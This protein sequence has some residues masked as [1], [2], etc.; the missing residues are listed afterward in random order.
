MTEAVLSQG[1]G[2]GIVLGLGFAFALLMIGVT[3]ILS[4][5]VGEIQDSEHF[6]T[7]S[8]SVKTGLISAAVVS[9]WTWPGTLLT[10]SGMAYEYGAAGCFWYAVGFTIQVTFFAVLA[11]QVKRIAPGAHTLVEIV[12]VR[13]G[14]AAHLVFLFYALGTNII[15]SAMLLLGGSQAISSITGMHVVAAGFLLP[16]GVWLYTVSGGLKSTFLSDWT[17]TVIVYVVIL[18]TLFVAYTSSSHI[19]SIDKMYELLTEVAK[20]HPS[21]GHEGSYLT[22]ANRDALFSG[23][24]IAIGGFA[25]VF[26]DPSYGQKAI[27]AKPASAMR[28]YIAGGLSWLIVPWAMGTAASLSC[29]ALIDNPVSVTYPDVVSSKEVAEGMPLL[30]GMT[31]LMGKSGASAGVLILFMACTSATSAELIAFSSVMTYD[32]YRTYLRPAA[33]GKELMNITHLFVTVFAVA[34]G[35]LAVLFNYIGITISW[36]LTFIGIALGPA[37]FGISL[38]L[39]WPKMS[40][41]GM[42]LGCPL[43]SVTGV[44]CW[45]ASS[46]KFNNGVVNKTT[47]NTADANAVGNFVGLF[48]GLLYIVIFSYIWPDNYDFSTMDSKFTVGDDAT[49]EEAQEMEIHVDEKAELDRSL[50]ISLIVGVSIFIALMILWPLPMFGSNYI[51]SKAFFRGWV[52]VIMIWC[53]IAA[54]YITFYP[55]YESRDVLIYLFNVL[56]GKQKAKKHPAMVHDSEVIMERGS[57][58]DIDRVTVMKKE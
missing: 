33:S 54:C 6:S 25:T 27:A 14:A 51:F 36:I 5:Y 55:L 7:A 18:V 44:V 29:L 35:A 37:V 16:L 3:Y 22:L 24:N 23:W 20:K 39:F 31:A 26:C 48:S 34:M 41:W 57:S 30:Y 42:I 56:R 9:S 45:V 46:Y 49:V 21:T 38:T 40:K 32:I 52:V 53:L 19:G 43:G 13:F 1:F 28:G 4:K 50:K 2:Y 8:R 15:V 11:I 12:R 58:S 47:L 10:S 17:H